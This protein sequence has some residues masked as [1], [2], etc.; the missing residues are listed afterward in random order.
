MSNIMKK[1]KKKYLIASALVIALGTSSTMA[2]FTDKEYSDP[3]ITVVIGNLDTEIVKGIN[4]DGLDI[5]IPASD[6]F[7]IENVGSLNQNL[8]F[9]FDNKLNIDNDGLEKLNY[10]LVF[11]KDDGT[12]S[13]VYSGVMTELFEGSI[14]IVS[15]NGE[16]IVLGKEE[17]LEAEFEIIMDKTMPSK[18]SNAD[19]KFDIVIDASQVNDTAKN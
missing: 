19:M 5:D 2:Y 11:T 17:V 6:K 8:S 16:K 18:Y 7:I 14:D 3:N 15:D 1:V 12:T 4:I 9:K 10:N 13:K